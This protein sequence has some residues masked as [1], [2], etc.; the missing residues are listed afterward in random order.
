MTVTPTSK[1]MVYCPPH[2]TQ[3]SWTPQQC[4]SPTTLRGIKRFS[5][6]RTWL[7]PSSWKCHRLTPG[8]ISQ[9]TGA[10]TGE[11]TGDALRKTVVIKGR[12]SHSLSI[13]GWPLPSAA[14]RRRPGRSHSSCLRWTLTRPATRSCRSPAS[15]DPP[16]TGRPRVGYLRAPTTSSPPSP[17]SPWKSQSLK[18]CRQRCWLYSLTKP[19]KNTKQ[20]Q[21]QQQKY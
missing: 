10:S 11:E 18:T 4:Q 13:T 8:Q 3:R 14:L 6:T 12:P 21:P 2:K 9:S 16:S 19:S 5:A 20:K 15:R 17:W 1:I 7:K